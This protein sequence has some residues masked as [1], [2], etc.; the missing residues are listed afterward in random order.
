M[1]ITGADALEAL[2]RGGAFWWE[3]EPEPHGSLVQLAVAEVT[4]REEPR[5]NLDELLK[6]L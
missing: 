6:P 3:P 4:R 1:K 2:R 5:P